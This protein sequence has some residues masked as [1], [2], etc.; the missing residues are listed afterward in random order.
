LLEVP[1]LH[2]DGHTFSIAF[3]VTLLMRAGQQQPNGIVALIRDD[4][5]R[6]QELR[7]LRDRLATLEA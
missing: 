5:A 3:T 6:R 2:R 7:S 4:T 1:A